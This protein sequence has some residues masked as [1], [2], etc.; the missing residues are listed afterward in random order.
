M[1]PKRA[2]LMPLAHVSGTRA[3][4]VPDGDSEAEPC[5]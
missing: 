3:T 5:A 1:R 2:S 4:A